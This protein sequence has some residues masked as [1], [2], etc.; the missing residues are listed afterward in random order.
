[1][2]EVPRFVTVDD[3]E[4]AARAALPNDV[5]GY[6]AGGAG[7]EWTLAQNRLSF[8]R[9]YLRPRV[10]RAS[11]APDSTATIFR[12]RVAMPV[13][14]APWAFQW[15]AHPDGEFATARAAGSAGALMVVSSTAMDHVEEIAAT[16]AGPKWWQLYVF[17]DRG[18]TAEMLNRVA[19]AGFG[20]VCLTVDFQAVGL[21]HRDTRSGFVLPIGPQSAD[22]AFDP[23]LSWDDLGWIREAAPGLPLLLKGILTTEDALMAVEAGVDG[24]VVSNHGGRQLDGAPAAL[25]VLPE[26]VAAVGGRIPVLMDGGIRRGTDIVK[27]LALGASAVM[28]GRPVAWGLAAAGE[29]GVAGVLEILRYELLNAMALSGCRTVD[30]ITAALVAPVA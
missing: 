5:Y 17:T 22:L 1:M 3:Y 23:S 28:V 21:R 20:A 26:I 14:V 27:A 25:T 7:D 16:G 15:M 10:L 19:A 12:Q 9:W 18:V 29:E 13:I 4:P 8:D 6:F 24:I 11:G 2:G 30:E